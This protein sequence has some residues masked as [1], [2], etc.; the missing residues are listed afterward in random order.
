MA[1]VSGDQQ[2]ARGWKN[3][4]PM[5]LGGRSCHVS[6]KIDEHRMIIVG[7]EDADGNILS[8]CFIYDVR[9]QQSTPLR[10][11]M[12]AALTGCRAVENDGFI[13]V[14]GGFGSNG[15]VNTVYRLCLDT[16]VWSIMAL[17]A[18]ARYNFAAA[19]KGNYI[20]VFGGLN[21]DGRPLSSAE[22][23]CIDN[24]TWE[25]LADMPRGPRSDH[26]A[27]ST[28]GSEIYIVGGNFRT[29]DV[30]DTGLSLAW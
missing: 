22:R 19:L 2:N 1:T 20:Y 8:S 14:I 17:M 11:D 7:G 12:P 18:T 27:V 3:Q 15:A 29:I 25:D 5:I 21:Y 26:C 13:Y 16:E 6:A 24:N 9:T 4:Q 28:T 23:Y 10:H 30:F